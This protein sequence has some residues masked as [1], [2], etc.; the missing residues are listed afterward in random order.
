VKSLLDGLLGFVITFGTSAV[1]LLSQ[2]GVETVAD[3]S[4]AAWIV[5]GVGAAVGAAK[6]VQSRLGSPQ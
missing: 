2:S 4:Q 1:A 6:T 5:A 3:V